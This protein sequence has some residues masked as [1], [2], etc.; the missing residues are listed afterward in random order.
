[1]RD[2]E[3]ETRR[4]LRVERRTRARGVPDRY[5]DARRIARAREHPDREWSDPDVATR[6]SSTTTVS[7]RG[8][9]GRRPS[10][11][12]VVR[13]G[14]ARRR[15]ARALR[16]RGLRLLRSR[17]GSGCGSSTAGASAI[18][19]GRRPGASVTFADCRLDDANFRLAQLAQPCGSPGS[20][21]R[22]RRLRR[23]PPRGRVFLDGCDLAGAD[24]SNAR[25][26]NGRPARARGST[27]C[28]A[29]G[30]SAARRS[31]VDQLVRSRAR[32]AAVGLALTVLAARRLG[33]TAGN[34]AGGSSPDPTAR[35]SCSATGQCRPAAARSRTG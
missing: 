22:P 10:R 21:L 7:R 11:G 4:H 6:S 31:R 24:F 35:I 20:V 33:G 23:R 29:S 16:P 5:I 13:T 30:R 34:P 14:A 3:D 2:E 19:L 8:P 25:C 26:T 12:R 18:E 17:S 15:R 1:M 32:P 9:G 27:V 28:G